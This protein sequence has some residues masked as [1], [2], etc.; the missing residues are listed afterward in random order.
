M[1]ALKGIEIKNIL[2]EKTQIDEKKMKR[3]RQWKEDRNK[4]RDKDGGIGL[5]SYS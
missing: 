1:F 4:D 2:L 3:L 5:Y